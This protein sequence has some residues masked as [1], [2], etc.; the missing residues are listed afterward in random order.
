MSSTKQSMKR[1]RV[2]GILGVGAGASLLGY[3]CGSDS[4]Q[5]TRD[6]GTAGDD[7]DR[8]RDDHGDDDHHDAG[9]GEVDAGAACKPTTSDV[10]GPYYQEG[11][12]KRTKIAADE[13]PGERLSIAGTVLGP[14]C[15]PLSGALVDVW[16]ADKDGTYHGPDAEY[17]LRGQVLTDKDGYYEF[18]TIMPGAYAL[19]GGFRPAH[20]HFTVSR[21]GY[22]PLTTQLYFQGDPFLPPND[23]CGSGCN[24]DEPDRVI[25]LDTQTPRRGVFDIVLSRA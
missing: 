16:Q 15:K 18:E 23:A 17:R 3:G 9:E 24:S 14:D 7:D 25:A 2:L 19:S 12:P 20:I 10:Q 1:R 22:A 21:P 11:A 5:S 13:E 8:D 4:K 6:G